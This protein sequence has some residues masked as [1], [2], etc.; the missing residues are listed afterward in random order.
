MGNRWSRE[1]NTTGKD[2]RT[3]SRG[4]DRIDTVELI[5]YLLESRYFW[6]SRLLQSPLQEIISEADLESHP[7]L[8][9]QER[10]FLV[11][12]K[13]AIVKPW[14]VLE[15]SPIDYEFN[16][17]IWSL[18]KTEI[19]E[20][21]RVRLDTQAQ[22]SK[23]AEFVRLY[24]KSRRCPASARIALLTQAQQQVEQLTI[25]TDRYRCLFIDS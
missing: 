25:E 7:F 14:E 24:C 8:S 22:T 6:E 4:G 2:C 15:E 13:P 20:V 9:A 16:E 11:K 5:S 19:D 17:L 1:D 21:V 10:K 18:S 23:L 3:T 12:I